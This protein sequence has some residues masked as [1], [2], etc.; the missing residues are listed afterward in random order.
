M[1][2]TYHVWSILFEINQFTLDSKWLLFILILTEVICQKK[3][4][5]EEFDDFKFID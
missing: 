2:K 1:I 5:T 3:L 4:K